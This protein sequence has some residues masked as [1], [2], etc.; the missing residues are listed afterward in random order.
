MQHFR[1]AFSERNKVVIAVVGLLVLGAT[2]L[3]ALN[4][5]ALPL[6]G[7]GT[8]NE[9]VFAESG[10]LRPGDEV[11][12]AGVR[13]GEVT[14][15]EIDGEQVRVEFRTED[16]FLTDRTTAAVKVKTML[17]QKF[18]S[19]DPLGSGELQG[20]IPLDRTTT[21]YD[22]NA[23]FSDLATNAQAIDTEQMETSMRALAEAFEDTPD[24]VRTM[25]SGLTD[26]SRTIS[27]RDEDLERLMGATE[28]VTGTLAERRDE[29]ALLITDGS[30]LLGELQKRREAV[31]TM[32]TGTA[33][34][35]EQLRGL[36]EDNDRSLAPAL[37]KL[38]RVTAIL[39]RN[40]ENLDQAA[41]MLGP[42]YRVLVSATGNGPWAEA[43]LC[44]LFDD[45]GLPVLENDAVRNC[46]PGGAR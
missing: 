33:E 14:A 40:Q 30:D 3:G 7:G 32:L 41:R 9:A 43:Y 2:F 15:V 6:L 35:G 12:V 42:Y 5:S 36:V 23:A 45:A 18:L 13:V 4:M 29:I 8:V 10:G 34:L 44:G 27:S 19:L 21:P 25:V 31:R 16:V 39:N 26:L 17:G 11:R 38:D 20:A 46:H 37:A 28:D 1:R 22:V 24:S